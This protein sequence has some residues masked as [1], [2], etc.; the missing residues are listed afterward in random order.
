MLLKG[1]QFENKG[2]RQC[3]E[4]TASYFKA[5]KSGHRVLTPHSE[6]ILNNTD[7]TYGFTVIKANK[8]KKNMGQKFCH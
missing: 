3:L 1:L 8:V 5:A 7:R 4:I 2:C 6:R